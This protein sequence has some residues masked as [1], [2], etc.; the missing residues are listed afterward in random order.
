MVVNYIGWFNNGINHEIP[1]RIRLDHSVGNRRELNTF[2][3]TNNHHE[4]YFDVDFIKLYD[5]PFLYSNRH[6]SR[7][8]GGTISEMYPFDIASRL[9]DR[10]QNPYY[11]LKIQAI[12]DHAKGFI[13][14]FNKLDA[15]G[16]NLRN[17]GEMIN[18]DFHRNNSVYRYQMIDYYQ[19]ILQMIQQNQSIMLSHPNDFTLPFVSHITDL[20][21]STSNYLMVDQAIPFYQMAIAGKISYSM[22]AININQI[23]DLDY[24]LL[25]ALE[26]GSNPKFTLSYKD[27]SLLMQTK[28]NTY[29]STEFNLLKDSVVQLFETYN[30]IIG[31]SNY[32]VKHEIINKNLIRVTYYNGLVIEIDYLSMTYTI[33]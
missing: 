33:L 15:N 5:K 28:Y 22:P 23:Y 14:D 8:V 31:P 24:Y 6:I 2:V 29:F 7:I 26:T 1:N 25:K 21:Y 12:N 9:P 17:F 4:L 18:S 10:T 30:E 16:I 13:N 27:T 3:N 20:T 11:L 32:I 19:D